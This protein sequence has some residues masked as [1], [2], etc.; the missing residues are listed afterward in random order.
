MALAIILNGL[1]R[2]GLVL[3]KAPLIWFAWA[4]LSDYFFIAL[5]LSLAFL[6]IKDFTGFWRPSRLLALRM[7]KDSWPMLFSGLFVVFYIK[8]DQVMIGQI[9][10]AQT[11][12]ICAVAYRVIE[13][14]WGIPFIACSAVFPAIIAAQKDK[15][16]YYRKIQLLYDLLFVSTLFLSLIL[17]FWSGFIVEK[18]FGIKYAAAGPV[19]AGYVWVSAI[20]FF[21][22]VSEKLIVLNGKQNCVFFRAVLGMGLGYILNLIFIPVMGYNGAA[23]GTFLALLISFHI[24]HF[25]IPGTREVFTIQNKAFAVFFRMIAKGVFVSRGRFE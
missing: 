13:L 14:I 1:V 12:G 21:S 7:V 17:F 22:F 19:L 24:V 25:F 6:K 15:N 23:L 10:D 11:A 9:L 4:V 5:F 20:A 16:N 3:L 2:V 18:I 8:L